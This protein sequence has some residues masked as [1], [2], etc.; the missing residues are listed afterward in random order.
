MLKPIE[1]SNVWTYDECSAV[2]TD[3]AN[4]KEYKPTGQFYQDAAMLCNIFNIKL[5]PGFK[6]PSTSSDDTENRDD[7]NKQK[8]PSTISFCRY[9]LDPNSMKALFKVLDGCQNI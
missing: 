7:Q 4:M 3:N 2:N 9:R 6:E 5:H 8:E 1:A